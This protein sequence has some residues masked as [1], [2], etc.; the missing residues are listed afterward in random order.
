M[1]KRKRKKA[2]REIEFKDLPEG[3][4]SKKVKHIRVVKK[5]EEG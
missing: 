1:A 4:K 3:L 2:Q 5:G